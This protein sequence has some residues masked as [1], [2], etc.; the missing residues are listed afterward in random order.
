[1]I[2][3]VEQQIHFA[4][5]AKWLFVDMLSFIKKLFMLLLRRSGYYGNYCGSL[6]FLTSKNVGTHCK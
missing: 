6:Q 1:V 5:L 4:F 2:V 3:K